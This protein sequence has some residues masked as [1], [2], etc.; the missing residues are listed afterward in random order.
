MF[1]VRKFHAPVCFP[2]YRSPQ[3]TGCACR[4]MAFAAYARS[5]S[6]FAL[7]RKCA[8]PSQRG[9]FI[10]S[11]FRTLLRAP[12]RQPMPYQW[13]AHSL[14]QSQ[15]ITLAVPVSYA[16]FVR[17]CAAGRKSTPLLSCACALFAKTTREGVGASEK[18]PATHGS[19]RRATFF[20]HSPVRRES[21]LT[22][23]RFYMRGPSV[24]G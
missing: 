17:S 5:Q 4:R 18:F 16:L 24:L 8:L 21:S 7:I 13:L 23:G 14:M 15:N 1:R 3:D 6:T 12:I 22:S 20:A 9:P 2:Q 11:S 10:P 19:A